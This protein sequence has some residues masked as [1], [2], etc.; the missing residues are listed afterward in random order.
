MKR[1]VLTVLYCL[2]F[3]VPQAEAVGNPKDAGTAKGFFRWTDKDGKVHYGDRLPPEQTQTGG[4]KFEAGGLSKKSIEGA[5]TPE[6]LAA[7]KRLNHLRTEQQ[8]LLLE[9]SD[10]DQALLRSFRSEKE[11]RL[12]LQGNINTLDTQ[13]KVIRAN[14]QR[15][16]E[17][18][19]P[20]QQRMEA[21]QKEG[22]PISKGLADNMNAVQLQIKT[23]QDQIVKTEAEKNMLSER[24]ER[25]VARL[26]TLQSRQDGA[27]RTLSESASGNAVDLLLGAV[28]CHSQATC[29]KAWD[30]ARAY[31]AQ[32]IPAPLTIDTERILR[33]VEP[34]GESEFALIVTHVSASL[35]D[36]TAQP[37][38]SAAPQHADQS[39]AGTDTLFL[40][41]RC[42]LSTAGKALCAG[43][44]AQEIRSG[45]AKA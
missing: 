26:N 21:V 24:A 27:N 22:K 35:G 12:A 25:D 9:Q 13:L 44:Q 42:Q 32:R 34:A 14:L 11:I 8:R 40:D 17:K 43:A 29:D 18:I 10:R 31:L 5:K 16:Q 1:A 38:Q 15:Q 23:Y 30:A 6:Q 2:T 36:T 39:G 19:A 3:A 28:P 41:V 33:T 7:E 20:L 45:F 4:V 37:P